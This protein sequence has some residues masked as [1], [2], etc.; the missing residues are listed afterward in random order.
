MEGDGPSPL[1]K[2]DP[3][4]CAI[5]RALCKL[6]AIDTEIADALEIDLRTLHR[7]K[8]RHPEFMAALALGKSVADKRVEESLYK[9]ATGYSYD[10]EKIVTSA[11]Q[12]FREPVVEHVPPNPVAIIFWLCNRSGG[13]WR[14]NPAP[15][16]ASVPDLLALV[17]AAA[18]RVGGDEPG[19][20]NP[21]L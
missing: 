10:S 12:I 9:I 19:P 5:A 20:E 1:S 15:G 17:R 14:R 16:D 3:K 11:G 6:G 8:R 21:I 4:Y 2:Y 7:W 13:K 18:P